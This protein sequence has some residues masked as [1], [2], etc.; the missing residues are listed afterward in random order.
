MG[1]VYLADDL[2]LERRVALKLLTAPDLSDEQARRRLLEEA[3]KAAVLNHPNVCTIHE[4]VTEADRT[5]IVMEYID[6]ETLSARLKRG[7][8]PPAEAFRIARRVA[9]ALAVAHRDPVDSEVQATAA[10][11]PMRTG[12]I[13]HRDIKPGNV[14]LTAGGNVKVLDFGVA[15]TVRAPGGSGAPTATASDGSSGIFG[16]AAYM[17]PE[18]VQQQPLDGRSDLFALGAVLYECLT[19]RRAFEGKNAIETCASVLH[20]DP[21]PPS[22]VNPVL[23]PLHDQICAQLLAK[24]REERVQTATAAGESLRLASESGRLSGPVPGESETG[25]L[26]D[27]V[28]GGGVQIVARARTVAAGLAAVVAIVASVYLVVERQRAPAAPPPPPEAQ[29]WFDRGVAQLHQ[30]AYASAAVALEQAVA[31]HDAYPLAHARLAEA[32]GQLDEQDRAL[33]ALIYANQLV[34]D[35]SRLEPTD[36]LH[37][38]AISAMVRRDFRSAVESYTALTE[39]LPESPEV[40]FELGRAYESDDALAAALARYNAA[41]AADNQYAPAH[42]RRGILLGRQNEDAEAIESFDR[43]TLLYQTAGNAEGRAETLY[44]RGVLFNNL[45]LADEASGALEQALALA[46]VNAQPDQ[47]IRTLAQL[48]RVARNAGRDDQAEQYARQALMLA[49]D[50]PQLR[51]TALIDL[52]YAFYIRRE[53]DY[54]E[55]ERYFREGIEV[56]ARFGARRAKARA[57]LSLAG[58]LRSGD[59]EEVQQ[60]AKAAL[61]FYRDGSYRLETLQALAILSFVQT[62]RGELVQAEKSLREQKAIATRLGNIAQTA[63]A[64]VSLG[65]VLARRGNLPA[66]LEEVVEGRTQYEQIGATR[67]VAYAMRDEASL[68][69]TLGRVENAR[70]ILG[71]LAREEEYSGYYPTLRDSMEMVEARLDLREN[72]LHSALE[73]SQRTLDSDAEDARSIV[74]ALVVQ[75]L[76]DTR[77]GRVGSG[78]AKCHDARARAD[79][80]ADPVLINDALLASAEAQLQ[81]GNSEGALTAAREALVGASAVAQ[82]EQAWRAAAL[83]WRASADVG[84]ASS[85]EEF[86]VQRASLLDKLVEQWGTGPVEHYLDRTDR[87]AL[88]RGAAR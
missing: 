82:L 46:A 9:K 16:T 1:E 44:Q 26:S 73:R 14:M 42:L 79:D 60:L 68:L 38:D 65:F 33:T 6:G 75:C 58:L 34:P 78:L 48:S 57:Q 70:T 61:S 24:R 69:A 31:I 64:G 36:A 51:A 21:P 47:Q 15:K 23:T 13:I 83:A 12:Q 72:R 37:L 81:A 77:L 85:V 35:R 86:D 66:A 62:F 76:A 50:R 88:A 52:G 4:V 10:T 8:I 74:E 80:D 27:P 5:F 28:A 30:A 32:R 45:R 39:R 17:S 20:V 25:P 87:V 43:A 2:T 7:P 49:E 22:Q 11:N 3:K 84:D 19:G 54:E 18:Q 40:Q 63:S 67:S 71:A 56:A 29:A 59:P 53:P 55:A 41:I